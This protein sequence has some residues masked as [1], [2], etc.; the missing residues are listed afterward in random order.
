MYNFKK[1]GI[2]D[3]I[4]I[5]QIKKKI[6]SNT[7]P[8]YVQSNSIHTQFEHWILAPKIQ[9]MFEINSFNYFIYADFLEL[10]AGS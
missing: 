6:V 10:K 2:S 7:Q 5:H 3:N 9:A 1:F 4:I 8:F